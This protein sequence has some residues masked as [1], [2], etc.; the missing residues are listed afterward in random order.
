MGEDPSGGGL[1]AATV[2]SRERLK[3]GETKTL[4]LQLD[5]EIVRIFRDKLPLTRT[6]RTGGG[7][8]FVAKGRRNTDEG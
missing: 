1:C 6:R 4:G 3:K 2:T 5:G 7:L 8:I